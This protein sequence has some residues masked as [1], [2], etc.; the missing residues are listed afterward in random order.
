VALDRE[1]GA[2]L[3]VAFRGLGRLADAIPHYRQVLRV[4]PSR[5]D[6]AAALAD[7]ERQLAAQ[8]SLRR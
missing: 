6:V 7:V 4:D 1:L 3:A 2:L 8:P 5:Q